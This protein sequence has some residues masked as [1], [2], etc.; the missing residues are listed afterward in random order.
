MA[1]VVD[2]DRFP[3]LEPFAAAVQA[4]RPQSGTWCESWTGRDIVAHQA[5]NAEE[6]ARVLSA[7]LAGEPVATRSFEGREAPYP[8]LPLPDRAGVLLTAMPSGRSGSLTRAGA[9]Q[10]SR[11]CGP[12]R[13]AR[14]ST[15]SIRS[16]A[17]PARRQGGVAPG[18][19]RRRGSGRSAMST[20][21][22]P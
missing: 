11:L 21:S 3:E 10:T 7:H 20:R 6:L 15:G 2:V 22:G 13:P 16:G 8:H 12:D 19:R 17:R 5:G 9:R 4:R 1:T 14:S 18:H